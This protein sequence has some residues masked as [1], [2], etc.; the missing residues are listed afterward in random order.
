[1]YLVGDLHSIFLR[2]PSLAHS[3]TQQ[4]LD[5]Y[6]VV[7]LTQLE[8]N[9][10]FGQQLAMDGRPFLD[11]ETSGQ[12]FFF[13]RVVHPAYPNLV[14]PTRKTMRSTIL[15]HWRAISDM[16]RS[17]AQSFTFSLFLLSHRLQLQNRI[18]SMADHVALS[19]DLCTADNDEQFLGIFVH[20]RNKVTFA[21]ESWAIASRAVRGAH[22]AVNIARWTHEVCAA[23]GLNPWLLVPDNASNVGPALIEVRSS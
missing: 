17:S 9:S 5:T 21:F 22:E 6:K 16:V 4:R 7:R 1:V 10:I 19:L 12:K 14:L 2:F 13:E 18:K 11:A 23:Y 15:A 20:F 8:Y 3:R